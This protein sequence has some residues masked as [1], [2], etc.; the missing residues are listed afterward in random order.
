MSIRN[1]TLSPIGFVTL[2]CM[3][4]NITVKDMTLQVITPSNEP[5]IMDYHLLWPFWDGCHLP[6]SHGS[7]NF[8]L[9]HGPLSGMGFIC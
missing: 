9:P 6:N 5:I 2:I 7:L 1:T 8:S 4:R 3:S